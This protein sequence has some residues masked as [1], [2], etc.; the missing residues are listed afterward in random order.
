MIP[1]NI[2]ELD[3]IE[4][5]N[6]PSLTYKWDRATN[7]I[8]GLVDGKQA[9]VQAI[10][11]ILLTIRYA[12]VI[13]SGELGHEIVDLVGQEA[14]YIDAVLPELIKE[15]LLADDRILSIGGFASRRLS[16][17]SME[18]SFTVNT[19][20]GDVNITTEVVL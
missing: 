9:V 14:D 11:K 20:E 8:Y 5:V 1:D 12:H 7:R 13:Y 15:A 17:D 4:T 18:I 3:T 16:I 2:N 19:V 6:N 10:D